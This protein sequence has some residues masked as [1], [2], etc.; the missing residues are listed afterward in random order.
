M[1]TPK[2]DSTYRSSCFYHKF[3]G[4]NLSFVTF[5]FLTIDYQCL[6][7]WQR[8]GHDCHLIALTL[9]PSIPR[10]FTKSPCTL[11]DIPLHLRHQCKGKR[12]KAVGYAAEMGG[13]VGTNA[14]ETSG[15]A[16]FP[17]VVDVTHSGCIH[18]WETDSPSSCIHPN[19]LEAT[20]PCVVMT[21]NQWVH[22]R[23]R[24]VR[25]PWGR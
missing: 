4:K 5:A 20:L 17:S 21:P 25:L 14:W 10:V 24:R 7:Q 16:T 3:F 12:Q 9:V 15:E 1:S 11:T 13:K 19:R 8:G 18:A 6:A 23:T 22:T 2:C